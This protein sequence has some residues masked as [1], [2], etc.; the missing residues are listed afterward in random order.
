MS[1]PRERT[2]LCER[3]RPTRLSRRAFT[4]IEL[5]VVIAIVSILAALLL[6]SLQGA[7]RAAR[8]AF[9]MNNQKQI[10]LALELYRDDSDGR[11]PPGDPLIPQGDIEYGRWAS[12]LVPRYMPKVPRC[13]EEQNNYGG[14]TSY[15]LNRWV[16]YYF[17]GPAHKIP[18]TPLATAGR[19]AP[20]LEKIVLISDCYGNTLYAPSH[21]DVT[22][23]GF[24][25]GFGWG[26]P[27]NHGNKLN[28][29]FM[30]GHVEAI[31]RPATGW[32]NNQATTAFTKDG[33]NGKP[34]ASRGPD[35]LDG[36]QHW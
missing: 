16:L 32:D 31:V 36:E 21:L 5:L 25:G 7:K 6:P 29:C 20:G 8:T 2:C 22:L 24:S 34:I 26:K 11:L 3:Q 14:Y 19:P 35:P 15:G 18:G 17:G 9:C 1:D 27:Q 12:R 30:D 4:L 13:P 10:F 33:H 28:F 23:Y